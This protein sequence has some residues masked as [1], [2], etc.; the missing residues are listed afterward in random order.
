[1]A[2]IKQIFAY[3]VIDSHAIPTLEGV[4]TLDNGISVV[5]SVPTN[6]NPSRYEAIELRD[7]NPQ[8]Y[9]GLGL[10]TAV[11]YI[12]N[13]ISPKLTNVDP[14]KLNA[15][16]LWLIK[17][18]GT[19]NKSKLGVNTVLLISQLIAKAAAASQNLPL[20]RFLNQYYNQLF[21][22]SLK[23]ERLPSTIFNMINGGKHANNN[24][25]IQE[26]QIIP[27]TGFSFSQ[28]Y[29]TAVIIFN[30]LKET[31]L[32]YAASTAV[33]DE[34]GF[35]PS[36]SSNIDA[37]EIIFETISKKNL[38]IGLDVFF[39]LDVAANKFFKNN[40][41]LLK[42]S[43]RPLNT[44]DFL[45]YLSNLLK[46][47]N[48]LAIED[49][50]ADDDWKGWQS[51]YSQYGNDIYIIGDDLTVTNYERLEKAI[52]NRLINSISI[53]PNQIGTVTEVLKVINLAKKNKINVIIS[54]RAGESNETFLADLALAVQADFV[55][56]GAPCRGE[57]VA[58]Y[59]R[60]LQIEKTEL[61]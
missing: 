30:Q 56:F 22:Q 12:N 9:D 16:D 21:N 4:L 31:I 32:Q 28:S 6:V 55:K 13:G 52:K 44:N 26:F 34:G 2:K 11:S 3:E 33:G 42:E 8:E 47:Y 50:F 53:K 54:H 51:F 29:Q 60:L 10:K 43:A 35:T 45:N 37:L 46:K 20:F 5:S 38:R 27:S 24:L 57:R 36:L 1:M 25:E 15:I 59:N 14:L 39:G 48:F 19:K 17:A 23:I 18:D 40:H 49:P 41:Y 7:N 58:K 61:K